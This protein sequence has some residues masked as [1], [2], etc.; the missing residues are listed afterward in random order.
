MKR[1]IAAFFSSAMILSSCSG[2]DPDKKQDEPPYPIPPAV[3]ENGFVYKIDATGA[4][5][6]ISPYIYG[7][8]V[9]FDFSHSNDDFATLVRFGGNRTTAFNW[10]NNASNAGSDWHHSSDDYIARNMVKGVTAASRDR[11]QRLLSAIVFPA[12]KCRCSP[13]P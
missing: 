7:L 9:D 13:S 12:I 4:G 1:L 3:E 5:G 2:S 10:E 6:R 11:W 8:N